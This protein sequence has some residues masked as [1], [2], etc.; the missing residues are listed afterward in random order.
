MAAVTDS[1]CIGMSSIASTAFIGAVATV[2]HLQWNLL[3]L[4][5]FLSD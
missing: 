5:R 3:V 1:I 4:S 2:E